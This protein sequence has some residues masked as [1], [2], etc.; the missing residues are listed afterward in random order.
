MLH[1]QT[2]S[3]LFA[4]IQTGKLKFHFLFQRD[5]A[6]EWALNYKFVLCKKRSTL[7]NCINANLVR[8]CQCIN[9]FSQLWI[10]WLRL[11]WRE[12]KKER[13]ELYIT[14]KHEPFLL[15]GPQK[16][17]SPLTPKFFSVYVI[18]FNS[19]LCPITRLSRKVC[20]L[21]M[22]HVGCLMCCGGYRGA[23]VSQRRLRINGHA[24][25]FPH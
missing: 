9:Y 20:I 16:L 6:S 5:R 15:Y 21:T 24:N 14:H 11:V 23:T 25:S 3:F 13:A 12:K 22:I 10:Q 8:M 4:F 1:F 2:V 7:V 17:I 19:G 18:A